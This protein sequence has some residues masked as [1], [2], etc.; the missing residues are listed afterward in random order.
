MNIK[1]NRIV[2]CIM[3]TIQQIIGRLMTT[4][5]IPS[6]KKW[7]FMVVKCGV[8]NCIIGRYAGPTPPINCIMS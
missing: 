4:P 3:Y 8:T 2:Y 1:E 6:R 5:I 7:G